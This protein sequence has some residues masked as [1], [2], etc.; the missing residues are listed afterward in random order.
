VFVNVMRGGPG[1]GNI[2]PEQADIKLACRGLGHGNTHGIVLAPQT[3]QEMLDLTMLSF[4][5]SFLYRLPVVILG[6]GYLG[7]MTG[8]VTLPRTMVEPGLPGWAVSGDAAHRG[9]LISSIQLDEADLEAHNQRLIAKYAQIAA[10]QQ[11]ADLVRCED[12]ELLLVACNT[13]AR[14]AKGAVQELRAQ[15]VKA[16]LF[17]P[18]T[19]WP[20]PIRPL[21]P[22][23]PHVERLVVVEAS[24]GQLEDELRLAFSHAGV[25][26]MPR[27][28]NIRHYG[29]VLPQQQ[30]IVEAVR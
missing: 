9:N 15:G 4:D 17:R 2:G 6:D 30:E 1:L 21:L 11:R 8:R 27:I 16:G 24:D 13:P 25:A 5:L 19:L 23:L 26:G 12:A 29:G 18:I 28:D 22:L 20:F 10:A 3:P 14:M 7:Q